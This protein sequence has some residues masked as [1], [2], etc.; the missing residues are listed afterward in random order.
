[1]PLSPGQILNNRYRIVKLL[2]QGGFGAVYR[3]WDANLDEPIA[4]KE[5]L[6]TSPAAQKQF[7]LEAKL[8][9]RL[10]HPNL[11]RVID[12]FVVPGQGQYL[13]MDFVEG[14]DLQEMLL[15]VGGPLPEAQVLQWIS[16]ICDALEYLHSQTPPIIHRDI[17]P[18]NIKITPSGKAMLVDFGIAKVYDPHLKTTAGA[19]AV[20]PG[21]SPHE[22]YGTG[23]TD[24]RTDIYALGATLY[25]LLTGAQPIESIQRVAHDNLPPPKV[26]VPALSDPVS[27]AVKC[28][29]Q[30]DPDKRFQNMTAFRQALMKSITGKHVQAT[31]VLPQAVDRTTKAPAR[32]NLS[33][34]F[35]ASK[36]LPWKW[37]GAWG[38]T[39]LAIA[40]WIVVALIFFENQKG[41]AAVTQTAAI[42]DTQSMITKTWLAI[43][44]TSTLV[45]PG[46]ST[47]ISLTPPPS[48]TL[49]PSPSGPFEYRVQEGDNLWS[50][51][52]KFNVDF[53]VLITV[54]NLDPVSP[55]INVG[56]VLIIPAPETQLPTATPLPTGLPGGTKIN[57]QVQL[58]D[59]LPSIAVKFNSTTEAIKKENKIENENQIFVGQ[60]LIVPVNLV[61]PI[62]SPTRTTVP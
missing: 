47:T 53:L 41:A 26:I 32:P 9:F 56:D 2:G 15:R 55:S 17:K 38:F 24:V 8:L 51:A 12:Y 61:T 48:N 37:I 36:P 30:I 21:Y 3:A 44:P 1:M 62:P 59:S 16:Q 34:I 19:R 7:Q 58:G 27:E 50:I 6:D 31:G 5:N 14:E 33:A 43:T 42:Q 54:N 60:L 49:T 46:P 40:I 22:Q 18:A 45:T 28:A 35:A 39:L 57:Y 23:A 52:Q 4:I 25:H 20:T 29:M 10:T 11:P 13:V